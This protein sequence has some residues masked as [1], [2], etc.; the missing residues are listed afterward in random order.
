MENFME[1]R[2]LVLY[3]FAILLFLLPIWIFREDILGKKEPLKEEKKETSPPLAPRLLPEKLPSSP[4]PSSRDLPYARRKNEVVLAIEKALPSIVNI[5]TEQL[6]A[7]ESSPWE[8]TPFADLFEE[9]IR[10]Q[11]RQEKRTSLGSGFLIDPS[12]LILTNA[13]VV[14]RAEK[15]HITFSDGKTASAR[16]LAE[17]PQQD[18]ALL[19]L[20]KKFPGLAGIQTDSSGQYFLGET[21]IAAGNPFGLDS[22]I[23]VGILS[24][25]GRR[26]TRQGKTLFSDILQTDAIVY[27]GNSGG[28]LLNIEGKLIGMNMSLYENAPGIGFA[29]PFTRISAS[30]VKWMIPE[31]TGNL[32][33]GLVPE[34]K[35]SAGGVFQLF[36]GEILP[37]SPAGKAGLS[38]GERILSFNGRPFDAKDLLAFNR[39][40]IRLKEK[41]SFTLVTDKKTYTLSLRKPEAK[42]ALS[43]ME[44]RYG[45]PLSILSPALAKHLEW[46]YSKA[47]VVSG[48]NEGLPETV[49][50]G[51]LL[52]KLDSTL[53]HTREDLFHALSRIPRG[54]SVRALFLTRIP[55]HGRIYTAKYE[56]TLKER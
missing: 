42:D 51:D 14:D 33:L 1:K 36:A 13:H 17:D 11:K 50:R 23:S 39:F 7:H 47:L 56:V 10:S 24:G 49:K 12:G 48:K 55:L 43:M 9:F 8:G 37:S 40:L 26:I 35:K 34:L 5:G 19:V 41:E 44:S 25:R 20:E 4:L 32:S 52:L 53:L 27:P 54:K 38:K 28:P 15:I 2:A 16:V 21:V 45:L 22:S 29:I 6:V 30:L 18:I 31:R 46:N 3:F